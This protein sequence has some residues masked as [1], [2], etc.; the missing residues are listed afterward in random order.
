MNVSFTG[1]RY[2]MSGDQ[3]LRVEKFLLEC[4]EAEPEE[5]HFGL[6]IESDTQAAE[7]A[8]WLGFIVFAHPA[9]DVSPDL[10]GSMPKNQ[11]TS[12]TLEPKPAL[13]RNHDIVDAGEV[14]IAAP[15]GPERKRSGTWATVRYALGHDVPVWLAW[16][17]GRG[18]KR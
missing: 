13:K 5:F 16:P 12:V 11:A 10:I 17:D 7:I 9:S 14:L 1:T 3:A 6:C 2:G 18:E 8:S 4:I 15:R